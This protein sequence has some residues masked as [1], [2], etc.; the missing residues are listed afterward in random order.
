MLVEVVAGGVVLV[1][2]AL[3]QVDQRWPN[4]LT[5]NRLKRQQEKRVP[6]LTRLG[7][8]VRLAQPV[9]AALG[10]CV[11][12]LGRL[13]PDLQHSNLQV[14]VVGVACRAG[15]AP[16]VRATPNCVAV[17]Q[18]LVEFDAVRGLCLAFFHRD[19]LA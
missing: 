7:W 8:A 4:K 11:N 19:D 18:C 6:P 2:Q 15:Q 5:V 10:H 17:C 16:V 12:A 9:I 3:S 14:F 1:L 13:V